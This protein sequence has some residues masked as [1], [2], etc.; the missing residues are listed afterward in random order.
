[1]IFEVYVLHIM[2]KSGVNARALVSFDLFQHQPNAIDSRDLFL[3]ILRSE[4]SLD[5]Q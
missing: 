5:D 3:G 4:L 2:E 1:M